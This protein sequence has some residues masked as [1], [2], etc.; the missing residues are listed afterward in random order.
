MKR[1]VF[2]ILI[3]L[4]AALTAA[5]KPNIVMIISDDHAWTDYG[6]MGHAKIK[7]PEIDKLAKHGL[8]F[9][10]GYV[11]SSLCCPSLASVITGLYPHQNGI[12]SNDPPLPSG[13]NLAKF[14]NSPEFQKGRER[15]NR[16][17]DAQATLPR[18]LVQEGYLALQ[19][20][21]WWQGDFKRG[22]FTHG[23]TMGGR[24][25]DAGLDI[26]RKTLEPIRD[27]IVTAKKEE[28]PFFVW[29][30]PLL[31]HDPHTPPKELLDKYRKI[32]PNEH[33]A[34]YCAMVEWFDQTCGAVMKMLEDQGVADNT[35]VVYLADN[36]W[37]QDTDSPRHAPKSKQSPYDGGLRTPI[38][39]SYPGKIAPAVSDT[40]VSSLDI[41]P[42]LLKLAG[43]KAPDGLPGIDL[44]DKEAVSKR[45]SVQGGIFTHNAVDLE[46]P[47]ASLRWRWM[48]RDGM[49]LLLPTELESGAEVEL[50]D[51]IRDPMETKNLASEKPA[52]VSEI[53]AAL[54][55]WWKP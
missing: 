31:P 14:R 29:Y 4:P 16:Y 18:L 41:M 28:K 20:G 2:L 17:M 1:I 48:L 33:I 15:M 6:F 26:G 24:H 12:T 13:M 23:M 8:A 30:A 37:I 53:T 43:I 50:Y 36:G 42:T 54:D 5:E 9:T 3:A 45:R 38:L 46:K 21:K 11:P 51:V 39:L 19:T 10:R 35:I 40:P 47:A 34:K 22:G 27:F 7:T 25:G 55:A 49:K 52:V 32:Q 44:T